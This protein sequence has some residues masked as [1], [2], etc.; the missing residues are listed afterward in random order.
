MSDNGMVINIQANKD[1]FNDFFHF[2][3]EMM[4]KPSFEQSQFDLIKSQ[5]LASLD[6]PYT[7]PETVAALTMARLVETYKPGDLRYHFEPELAKTE[8]SKATQAQVKALY[9]RFFAMNHARISVT[10][11]FDPVRMKQTLNQNFANWNNQEP[12]KKLMSEYTAYPAQKVH[13]LSEQREFGNYQALLTFPVGTEH[14]DAPAMLVLAQILGDSQI[15]SRLAVALRE[16]NALV[17]GFGSDV[18]LDPDLNNGVLSISANYT[19]GKADQLSSL[20]HEVL[21][22]MIQK[23]VTDQEVAAAKANIMKKR[24]TSLEDERNIHRMLNG[25]IEYK[26]TLKDRL[27]RDQEYATITKADVDRV[28]KKYIQ[29]DHLVE[30]MADQYGQAQSVKR[31]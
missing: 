9:D 24:V 5:S 26:K 30:V 3:I 11:D 12:Y 8:I 31:S 7:E 17:Y 10:G 15:S 14:P 2:M 22:E 18:D 25:Q 20:I 23:G 4:K 6:R 21:Q 28:I 27:K 19:A 29:L 13:A 1:Q 16:K